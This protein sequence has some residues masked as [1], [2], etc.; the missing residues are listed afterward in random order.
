VSLL[1]D[2]LDTTVAGLLLRL[3]FRCTWRWCCWWL[4]LMIDSAL[5][6]PGCP[7]RINDALAPTDRAGDSIRRKLED[8]H[9]E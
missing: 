7:E 1:L 4:L 3:V 8:M 2:A 5:L 6:L 9:M